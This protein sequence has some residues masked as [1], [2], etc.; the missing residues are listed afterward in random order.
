MRFIIFNIS[1]FIFL[2][3]CK[4]QKEQSV[5]DIS[6]DGVSVEVIY[7]AGDSYDVDNVVK[8]YLPLPFNVAIMVHEDNPSLDFIILSDRI[9]KGQNL[10]VI[11]IGAM[12][13]TDDGI[14]K[15]FFIA[16]PSSE[17]RQTFK[18]SEFSDFAVE[19]AS[20]KWIIEK[21]FTN[22][23]GFAKVKLLSWEDEKYA[24]RKIRATHKL[25]TKVK[26]TMN[27]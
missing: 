9:Y 1:F 8:P 18:A 2:V 22:H 24:L 7:G 20:I 16:I 4:E 19:H 11:P 17:K 5:I 25:K 12:R 21:Y 15:D 27:Y 14:K 10:N 13:L 26:K 6:A 23:K 3:S